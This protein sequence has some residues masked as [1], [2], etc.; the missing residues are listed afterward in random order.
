MSAST[1]ATE[2][3]RLDAAALDRLFRQARSHNRWLP[4]PVAPALLRELY[5]LCAQG[6]T[7]ANGCPARFVFIQD[8]AARARLLP[9]LAPGNR[10]KS[11]QAPVTVLIAQDLAFHRHMD[12]LFAHNPEAARGFADKPALAEATAFRNSSLQGAY[13]MLAARALGLD[14]GPMSGF[15]AAGVEREFLQPLQ[16]QG[17]QL[18]INFLCNLGHGDPA[19]LFARLPRL[20]F[21]EACW[22]L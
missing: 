20:G 9:L 11:A 18:R 16:R 2:L 14:C 15:D 21:D 8:A 6:P 10:D 1:M 13:L 4:R 17:E 5:A 22:L 19:G 3:P 12:R 7:S